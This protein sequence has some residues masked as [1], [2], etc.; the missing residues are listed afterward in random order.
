MSTFSCGPSGETPAAAGATP[1]AAAPAKPVHDG[2]VLYGR[3]CVSCH[4]ETGKGDG[5]SARLLTVQPRDFT[6]GLFKFK[7]NLEGLPT[8]D[9][10]VRTITKGVGGTEMSAYQDLPPE[11]I[12]SIVQH[13]KSL[14]TGRVE[15][16]DDSMLKYLK[17]VERVEEKDGKKIAIVNW[18]K[19]RGVG[20]PLEVPPAP[21]ST[22]ELIAR[23]REV[24]LK[25]AGCV[26][27]H[28]EGGRGDGPS[29]EELEDNWGFPIKPRDLTTDVFKGGTEPD[30]VYRRIMVGIPGTPMPSS[31][32]VIPKTEDQW[33]LVYFVLSLRSSA[34]GYR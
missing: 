33:A 26:K 30:D 9:D 17:G 24:F 25:D 21:P 28:G 16:F 7:S 15:L 12:G 27:C 1:T 13:V 18:F 32:G 10:L 2:R 3:F 11:A 19:S 23:G 31:N 14:T 20:A 34:G 6:K 8:D 29:A 5:I 22:P 4:G